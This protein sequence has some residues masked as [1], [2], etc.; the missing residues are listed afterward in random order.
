V[1]LYV[2]HVRQRGQGEVEAVDFIPE[3]AGSGNRVLDTAYPGPGVRLELFDNRVQFD[4]GVT[5][6]RR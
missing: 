6:A 2:H 3:P 1:D 5:P 4:G